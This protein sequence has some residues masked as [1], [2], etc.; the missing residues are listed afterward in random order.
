M[1]QGRRG[2]GVTEG[3][4]NGLRTALSGRCQRE[5]GGNEFSFDDLSPSRL[6][7]GQNDQQRSIFHRRNLTRGHLWNLH[8]K[9]KGIILLLQ[10]F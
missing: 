1:R 9:P 2:E 3:E 10:L 8:M 6:C 4:V 5:N 7:S